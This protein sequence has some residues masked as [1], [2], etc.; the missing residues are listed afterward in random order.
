ML[1]LL[2][3]A[4]PFCS[5]QRGHGSLPSSWDAHGVGEQRCGTR[6]PKTAL[7]RVPRG[8]KSVGPHNPP[9]SPPALLCSHQL[10]RGC[11]VLHAQT[12]HARSAVRHPSRWPGLKTTAVALR[13]EATERTVPKQRGVIF[14]LPAQY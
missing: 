14:S 9:P 10:T 4:L 7:P 6:P 8:S 12:S 2:G 5:L 1:A 3:L 11:Q 13:S